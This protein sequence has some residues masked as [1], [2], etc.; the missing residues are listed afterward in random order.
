MIFHL[1][2][3]NPQPTLL[4]RNELVAAAL[5][6]IRE[7]LD[8]GMIAESLYLYQ[9]PSGRAP[10]SEAERTA[11]FNELVSLSTLEGLHY[12]SASRN[13][14]RLF[15]ESSRVIDGPESQNPV[16]DPVYG[17]PPRELTL[18]ARQKDLTFGDNI[19]QYTYYARPDSLMLTQRNLTGMNYGPLPVVG[20]NRLCSLLAVLDTESCL[21]IYAVSMAKV[22]SLPLLNR[23][24]GNSFSTRLEALGSWFSGRADRVFRGAVP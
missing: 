11:L 18:Y 14:T 10:W 22:I 2:L 1:Q 4:P 17:I 13:E 7:E 9:K 20:K 12:F 5:K 21:V 3:K 19:Y 24:V 16:P 8:P 15:Y 6:T 23:R